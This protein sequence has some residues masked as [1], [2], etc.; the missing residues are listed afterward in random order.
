MSKHTPG[1]WTIERKKTAILSIGPC[2]ADEYAGLAWL[3]LN[4]HDAHLIASAPEILEALEIAVDKIKSGLILLKCDDEFIEK[5]TRQ[6]LAAIAKAKGLN[7]D[8]G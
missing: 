8:Q 2:V 6:A 4:E 7:P 3:D 1:P 5:E